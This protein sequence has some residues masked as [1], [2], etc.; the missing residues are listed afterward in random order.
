LHRRVIPQNTDGTWTLVEPIEL[1]TPEL[2]VK[3][4][5][6]PSGFSVK[7]AEIHHIPELQCFGYTLQEPLTQPRPLDAEAAKAL[8]VSASEK[9]R[10]LKSGFSV[11]NED[12]TRLVHAHDVCGEPIR[13]RKITILG[14]CCLVPPVMEQLAMN[15]DVLIHEGTLSLND[16]GKKADAGGHST[17]AQAAIFANKTKSQV[18]V[19]NHLPKNLNLYSKCKEWL[20]EAESRIRGPTKVQLGYDHLEIM[21]PRNGF[22][23]D[24]I[25]SSRSLWAEQRQANH[26]NQEPM[27]TSIDNSETL[28]RTASN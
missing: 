23:F 28:G 2:A 8:G 24:S 9:F 21:I 14:D 4:K 6:I 16:T 1:T 25:E 10:M 20:Y 13:P 27:S 22:D 19:I 12:E 17:A 7:A 15:S 3:H 26:A 18:L 11:M 5:S